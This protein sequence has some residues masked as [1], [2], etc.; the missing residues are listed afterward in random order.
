MPQLPQQN[1]PSLAGTGDTWST[2]QG[3][4]LHELNV[5]RLRIHFEE[6]IP[7]V[8]FRISYNFFNY[9]QVDILKYY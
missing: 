3:G 8:H 9:S 6:N 4:R 2:S 1:N 5:A 7:D